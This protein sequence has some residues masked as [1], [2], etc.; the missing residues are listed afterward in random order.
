[1]KPIKNILKARNLIERDKKNI[2]G[3]NQENIKMELI[4]KRHDSSLRNRNILKI[5]GNI[6]ELEI[7]SLKIK[8]VKR[9]Q[10]DGEEIRRILEK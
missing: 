3:K 7:S 5:L 4:I 6:K 8:K 10:A 1:M 9:H 2:D